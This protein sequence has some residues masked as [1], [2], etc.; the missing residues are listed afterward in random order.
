MHVSD[1][2]VMQRLRHQ[3]EKQR[4]DLKNKDEKL[5]QESNEI[6]GVS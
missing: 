4:E 1:F 6:E 5:L 3:I 2:Q